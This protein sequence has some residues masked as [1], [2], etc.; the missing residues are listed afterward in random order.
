M[1]S[2][3]WFFYQFELGINRFAYTVKNTKQIFS[4]ASTSVKLDLLHL[5]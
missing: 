4:L 1:I 2:F 3:V 5:G